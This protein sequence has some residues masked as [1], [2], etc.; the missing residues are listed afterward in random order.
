MRIPLKNIKPNPNNPRFIRNNAFKDLLRSVAQFPQMLDKRPIAVTKEGKTFIAL[1]GNQRTRALTQLQT[2]INDG[3]FLSRYETTQEAQN[4][5]IEYFSKGVPAVDCT[6]L[7]PDQQRRFIIADNLPFGEWDT[8]ALANE[9]NVEELTEWG[10]SVPYWEASDVDYSDKNKEID[11]N[12]FS[13][14][15]ELKFKFEQETYNEVKDKL[16]A[17]GETIEAGLLN[18]LE[19]GRA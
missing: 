4:L 2:E 5:L 18:L 15:M 8:D 13:D 16:L 1:G 3:S 12:D 9:W 17:L 14:L 11:V 19:N 10:L 6:D 7:T